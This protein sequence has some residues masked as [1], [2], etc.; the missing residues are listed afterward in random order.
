MSQML[1]GTEA[2]VTGRFVAAGIPAAQITF[3]RETWRFQT[4]GAP[5]AR[6]TDS[7]EERNRTCRG[8]T[9]VLRAPLFRIVGTALLVV[10]VFTAYAPAANTAGTTGEFPAL[11]RLPSRRTT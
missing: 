7:S 5:S 9:L 1:W 8:L 3:S 11:S 6:L 2:V 10:W 4:A